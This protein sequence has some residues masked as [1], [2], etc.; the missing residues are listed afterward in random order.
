MAPATTT[1]SLVSDLFTQPAHCIEHQ[2]P[3]WAVLQ[4][5]FAVDS[6]Q[7][8][9]QICT[10]ITNL[11]HRSM[12]RQVHPQLCALPSKETR[13][14]STSAI[15]PLSSQEILSTSLLASKRKRFAAD[16]QAVLGL[17]SNATTTKQRNA[18]NKIFSIWTD[19]WAREGKPCTF[20]TLDTKDILCYLFGVWAPL[21]QRRPEG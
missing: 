10:H 20:H 12:M 9:N 19:F 4:N 1:P 7:D 16:L 21:P 15:L 2:Q 14:T 6:G 18:T 11:C 8:T 5:T 3:D 17:A 13:T